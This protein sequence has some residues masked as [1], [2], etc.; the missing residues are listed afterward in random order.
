M[1]AST[2][3]E[4]GWDDLAVVKVWRTSDGALLRTLA[5]DR[6]VRAV[7]F[8]PG[9]NLLASTGRDRSVTLWRLDTGEILWRK[10]LPDGGTRLA[11]SPDGSTIAIGVDSADVQVRHTSDGTLVRH[12]DVLNANEVFPVAF[13]PDGLLVASDGDFPWISIW[14]ISDG[15]IVGQVTG[16]EETCGVAFSP[17]GKLFA[18]SG[19]DSIIRLWDLATTNL[20]G[21]LNGRSATLATTFSPDGNLIAIGGFDGKIHILQS[22][23]GA[24]LR[25]LEGHTHWINAL[26]FSPDGTL[27]ASGSGDSYYKI[28]RVSD[29]AVL[30]TVNAQGG[31][32]QCL[33]FSPDGSLLITGGSAPNVD[34]STKLWRMSDGSNV[35]TLPGVSWA[36]SFS[37]DGN[38]VAAAQ[39]SVNLWN[40]QSGTLFRQ[41]G[42]GIG[43]FYGSL[44]FTPDGQTVLGSGRYDSVVRQWRISDGQLLKSF[45][46]HG[47][48]VWSLSMAPDGRSFLA[49]G[50]GLWHW[51]I[52]D[53]ALLR[54]MDQEVSLIMSLAFA[55]DGQSLA[56]GRDDSVTCLARTP[57]WITSIERGLGSTVISWQ[58]GEA[59]YQ[60]QRSANLFTNSWVNFDGVVTGRSFTNSTT[61]TAGF[62]R[63][64]SAVAP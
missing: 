37:P 15:E 6:H 20:I 63:I 27:L 58:G 18:S 48:G 51:R 30:R 17:D 16:H 23:N 38:L 12:F 57:L 54:K 8:G 52:S 49:G 19:E 34:S 3:N 40:V 4:E 41:F 29:G 5:H 32:V 2:I 10:D 56:Y 33:A 53:G 39:G 64:Q 60:V 21:E 13:S 14:R 45:N 26:A 46:E 7:A 9:T 43:A 36:V 59:P 25:T 22:S 61:N 55:P 1:A 28:W 11:F 42:A 35:L 62:F 31:G 47:E 44:V 50:F 24:S